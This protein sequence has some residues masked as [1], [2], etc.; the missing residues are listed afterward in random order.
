MR[1]ITLAAAAAAVLLISGPAPGNAG[2]LQIVAAENFY[3][4]VARQ[5]GGPEVD[6]TSILSNPNQDPHDFEASA[7]TAR[8]IADAALIVYSGADYDPWME[9]LL[10]ASKSSTRRVIVVADLCIGNP[11]T[12][13]I[14]G[15]IPPAMPAVAKALPVEL[16]GD[17]PS[18]KAD[19]EEPSQGLSAI[20]SRR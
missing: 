9:K 6:V 4:D 3:G 16:E 17:D 7:S 2:P 12:I 5:I 20:R 13:L 18:H 19:Y 11:A 15:M 10:S 14:S 1:N 8:A